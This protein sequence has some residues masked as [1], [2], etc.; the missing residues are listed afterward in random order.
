MWPIISVLSLAAV[1]SAPPANAQTTP[2]GLL[3]AI[4]EYNSAIAKNPKDADAL[5]GRALAY[6]TIGRDLAAVDDLSALI[7]LTPKSAAAFE[8]RATIYFRLEEYARAASDYAAAAYLDPKNAAA[9]Y[10]LGMTQQLDRFNPA[11]SAEDHLAAA[12]AIQSDIA[13]KMAARGV[14]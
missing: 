9:R 8:R 11:G 10:G 5:L 1:V 13:E 12:R 6:E 14:K 3:K 7:K 4:H 2:A